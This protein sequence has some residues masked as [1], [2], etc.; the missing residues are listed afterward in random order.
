MYFFAKFTAAAAR[1][2]DSCISE[3]SSC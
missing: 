3:Q 2:H 1:T